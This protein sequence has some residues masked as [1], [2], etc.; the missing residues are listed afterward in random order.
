MLSK[1]EC[2]QGEGPGCEANA[3][4]NKYISKLLEKS[5]ANREQTQKELLE[6]YWQQGYGDYFSFGYNKKLVKDADGKWSLQDPDNLFSNAQK[7]LKNMAP[8]KG[9]KATKQ[10]K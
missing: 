6:K 5:K 10:A 2:V 8:G 1:P 4:E 9:D 3:S 7:R